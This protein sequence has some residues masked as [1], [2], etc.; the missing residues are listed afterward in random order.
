MLRRLARFSFRHRRL[1]AA[2]WALLFLAGRPVDRSRALGL[3]DRALGTASTLGMAAVAEQIQ[4][5]RA[6]QTG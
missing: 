1:V 3:L 4:T 2:V 6:A 5:L